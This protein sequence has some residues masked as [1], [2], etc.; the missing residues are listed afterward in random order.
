M[1][2]LLGMP[3]MLDNVMKRGADVFPLIKRES[4]YNLRFYS[5][6][7]LTKQ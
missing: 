3:K 4:N 6:Y 2:A 1:P 5:P 7:Q